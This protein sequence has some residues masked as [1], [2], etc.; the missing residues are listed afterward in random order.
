MTDDAAREAIRRLAEAIRR[1]SIFCQKTPDDAKRLVE[2]VRKPIQQAL[3]LL[4]RG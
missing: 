4:D 1:L 2:E 3:E